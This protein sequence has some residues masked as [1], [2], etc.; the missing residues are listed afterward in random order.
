MT[1]RACRWKGKFSLHL[2]IFQR[3]AAGEGVNVDDVVGQIGAVAGG[4]LDDLGRAVGEHAGALVD[5][6]QDG[7]LGERDINAAA[8]EV[9][10]AN[11][12]LRLGKK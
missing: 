6:R 3:G 4:L 1:P 8:G 2:V 11:A 12:I 7:A 10:I 9:A 5:V